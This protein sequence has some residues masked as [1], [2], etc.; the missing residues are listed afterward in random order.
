MS[1]SSND[2]QEQQQLSSRLTTDLSAL[3]KMSRLSLGSGTPPTGR[4]STSMTLLTSFNTPFWHRTLHNP[5]RKSKRHHR[6]R[7]STTSI[8]TPSKLN[9]LTTTDPSSTRSQSPIRQQDL[10]SSSN[11]DKD[12]ERDLSSY[13]SSSLSIANNYS[14]SV[15][16]VPWNNINNSSKKMKKNSS[17]RLP[18]ILEEN[19]CSSTSTNN[20]ASPPQSTSMSCSQ[21]SEQVD[22]VTIDELASYLDLFVYIPKKMSAQAEMMYT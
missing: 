7:P 8:L 6:H 22:D 2:L 16:L 19:L 20:T 17:S 14:P 18:T 11:V 1:S 15:K 21:Q 3:S 9:Y 12:A 10:L 5:I 4:Q 13:L